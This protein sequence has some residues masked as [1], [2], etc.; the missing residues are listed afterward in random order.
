MLGRL[1]PRLDYDEALAGVDLV[2]ETVPEVHRDQAR[3]ARPRRSRWR[4]RA[5]IFATGTSSMMI[6]ELAGAL[7]D[8]GRL[9]GTHWFYP[10]N[11]MP[12]VEVARGELTRAGDAVEQ[13]IG[14]PPPIGKK[15]VVRGMRRASS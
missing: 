4:R 6:S 14:V 8:P 10:A 13:V 7:A 12:L 2:F 9:V 15:P 3:G 5:R 1:V 11:I